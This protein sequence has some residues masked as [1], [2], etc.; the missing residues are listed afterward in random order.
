MGVE[1]PSGLTAWIAQY[2]QIVFFFAQLVFWLLLVA[3]LAWAAFEFRRLVNHM[4]GA[5][6]AGDEAGAADETIESETEA[7]AGGKKVSVEEF[8]E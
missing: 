3:V 7:A 6:P 1:A 5:S 8:V 2:G 4:V